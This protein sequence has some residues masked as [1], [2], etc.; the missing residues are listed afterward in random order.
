MNNLNGFTPGSLYHG[1]E[2]REKQYIEE[3]DSTVLLFVHTVLGTPA[4]AIKNDDANKTFCFAFETHRFH[5][6]GPYP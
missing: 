2:L 6:R 5:R 1:F 3:I 4:L